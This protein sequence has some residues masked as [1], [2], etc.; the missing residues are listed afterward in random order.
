MP[1]GMPKDMGGDSPENDSWMER[2]VKKVTNQTDKE[3]KKYGIINFMLK[4]SF[5]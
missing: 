4:K 1:Y 5:Q 3:G 2:C